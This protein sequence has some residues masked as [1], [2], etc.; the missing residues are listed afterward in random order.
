MRTHLGISIAL[1]AVTGCLSSPSEL[2]EELDTTEQE[3]T[4]PATRIYNIVEVVLPAGNH[5]GLAGD[6]CVALLDP[7]HRLRKVILV[8]SVGAGGTCALEAF[9][10]GDA[11]SF[12]WGDTGPYG[13]SSGI[14]ALRGALDD[15]NGAVH[16]LIDAPASEAGALAAL[17]GFLGQPFDA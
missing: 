3:A 14:V 15:A 2:P 17:T 4:D 8:E 12:T 7:E 5:D 6:E 16:R 11:L 1:V 9:S 13:I 10:A